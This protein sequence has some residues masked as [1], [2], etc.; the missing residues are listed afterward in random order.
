MKTLAKK[1]GVLLSPEGAAT[2]VALPKLI[3]R[4]IISVKDKIVI[5][6]TGSGFTT[7]NYLNRNN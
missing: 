1:A 6:G 2:L 7:A 4:K 5:F 3:D